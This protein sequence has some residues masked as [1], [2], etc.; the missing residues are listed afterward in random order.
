MRKTVYLL[1]IPLFLSSNSVDLGFIEISKIIESKIIESVS[2]EE[3]KTADI[4]ETLY[5]Q[6][7]S[8][9]IIRR[10]GIANDI[11]IRGQ[12]R[13]N[14]I[15][16]MDDSKIYGACPNRMD[17]PTSHIVT[18]AIDSMSVTE[19]PYN[20]EE[21]GNL[22]GSINIQTKQPNSGLTTKVDTTIGSFDYQKFG[23]S[24]GGGNSK[25]KFLINASTQTSSQ[26]KDGNGD[27]LAKQ[28]KNATDGTPQAMMQYKDKYYHMDAYTKKTVMAKLYANP[29]KNQTLEM[30]ISAN[31]SDDVMYANSKMDALNDDSNIYN[32][33]YSIQDLGKYSKSL[34]FQ[35]YISDVVH[36]MSTKYRKSS[37]INSAN[38]VISELSTKMSGL[39]IINDINISRTVLS[40]GIDLSQRNWDGKY[41]GQGSKTAITGRK[42]I[43]DTDTQNRALFV[44]SITN[45]DDINIELGARYNDTSI[46][47]RAYRRDFHSIDISGV[48]SCSSNDNQEYFIGIGHAS[49]VPDARELYFTSSMNVMSGTPTLDQTTNT[50]IDIG[51]K[52]NFENSSIKIKS[53][54]SNLDNYIYFNKSNT[55]MLMGK[56]LAY[57]SFENIDAYI[58][59]F[60]VS[61]SY[62][63]S[64]NLYLDYSSAYQR[65]KKKHALT[66]QTNKNLADISPFRV[67][68]LLSYDYLDSLSCSVGMIAGKSWDNYDSDNAEQA[69]PGYMIFDFKIVK[70][71][72]NNLY[73]TF[74]VDN[75]LDKTYAVS[76]TYADLILLSDGESSE[77]MLLNE[78]GRYFYMNFQ[79]TF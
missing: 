61:G 27:I 43:D 76:N 18:S 50:Q 24:L 3:V 33:K 52:I 75:I 58:Y 78:P 37:G 71:W 9:N 53:F 38:E 19:G 25:L 60:E 8:I 66:A 14:I 72:N 28:I 49:R 13:D 22:S 16:T 40:Y 67:N 32:L 30:S 63:F 10:S 48:F 51:T 21:F 1:M 44:K 46:D 45:L 26:Y 57:H 36:P 34:T 69:L 54:Y 23:I 20:V 77:V 7:P 5:K 35:S 29:T 31:R 11:T 59:G 42:S 12:K 6:I 65:G 39:K 64:E 62:D 56:T 68:V 55:T 17:P 74:G 47:N 2:E 73:T 4:A 41:I 79:Y 15:V 70:Q